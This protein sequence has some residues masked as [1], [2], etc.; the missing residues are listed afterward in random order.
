M[1]C[2]NCPVKKYYARAY[3]MHF[4]KKDCPFKEGCKY[5]EIPQQ[6]NRD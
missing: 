3:D 4:D 2:D 5:D 6:E 1:A